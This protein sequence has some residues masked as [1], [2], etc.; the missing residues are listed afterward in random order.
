LDTQ[1]VKPSG[2]ISGFFFGWYLV[3]ASWLMLFL[4]GA[5]AIGLYFKPMLDEFGWER[6]AL[7][8]VGAVSLLVFAAFSPFLGRLID[9]FGTRI[10]LTVSIMAQIISNVINGFAASLWHLYIVRVLGEMKATHGTQVLVNRWFVKKRGQ[11]LGIMAT[12]VPVG[13]LVF[14]PL[15]QYLILS[16]GWRITLWFWAA[17]IAAL[18]LPAA[19]LVRNR[20]EEMG[21]LPDGGFPQESGTYSASPAVQNRNEAGE[22]SGHSLKQA[23]GS[24]SFW[25][26][27]ATQLICGIGCGLMMTHSVILATDLGYSAMIGASFLSVQGGLN[28]VGVLVT[29]H[30]SDRTSR[31]R[32]LSLT[33]LFRSLSFIGLT[34]AI[35]IGGNT[36]WLLY[37]SMALFGLGWYTTAPLTAGLV[38]DLFGFRRLGTLLGIILAAHMLGMACG[39]YAGG[40]SYQLTGSYLSIFLFQA[41]A[42]LL[43]AVFAFIIKRLE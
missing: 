25:L 19:L 29:G 4:S 24:A 32:V 12:G 35:I 34:S 16:W 1:K 40:L 9:R 7:S 5:T 27:L 41:V 8:L 18:L 39:T 2:R 6:A 21:L 10:I 11:A 33:H 22:E 26:I 30:M 13:V 23:Y 36:L 3:T 43:A 28:L 31:N 14:S 17:V 15:S 37:L 42:E 38:A 20:P